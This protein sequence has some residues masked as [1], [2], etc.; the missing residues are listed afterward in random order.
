[1]TVI[2]CKSFL[3]KCSQWRK[4]FVVWFF[5]F[6]KMW[7]SQSQRI[8][9]QNNIQE[10]T[11][12]R[13]LILQ[14]SAYW[15]AWGNI[16]LLNLEIRGKYF[17]GLG[18]HSI[19]A[20]ES[21][22]HVLVSTHSG[23]GQV[24]LLVSVVLTTTLLKST[25]LEHTIWNDPWLAKIPFDELNTEPRWGAEVYCSFRSPELQHAERLLWNFRLMTPKI[26][27]LP[28]L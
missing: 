8:H 5:W 18:L 25:A 12:G 9:K 7:L 27:R 19:S 3:F 24:F 4:S 17:N 21:L 16:K 26:N 15:D 14:G 6:I 23:L 22:G 2:G 28:Q 20:P 10:K 11:P 1:M 13:V